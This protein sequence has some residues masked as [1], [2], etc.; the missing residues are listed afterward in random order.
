MSRPRA[1]RSNR[2]PRR[3]QGRLGQARHAARGT[4]PGARFPRHPARDALAT[5]FP[6]AY[7]QRTASPVTQ[8]ALSFDAG[9]AADPLDRRGIQNMTLRAA[10]RRRRRANRPADRGGE[11]AARRRRSTPPAAADRS[12]VTLSALSANLAPSLALMRDIVLTPD[13]NPAEVDRVRGQLLTA[14]AQAKKNPGRDRP[15]RASAFAVRRRAI[16]MRRPRLATKR[17]SRRS[18]ATIC[19]RSRTAGCGPTRPSCSSFP[20]GRWPRSCRCSRRRSA[21]GTAPSAPA[22]T[23]NFSVAPPAATG[24]A[25]R[26]RRPARIRRSRSSMRARSRRSSP[27]ADIVPIN[28]ATDVFGGATASRTDLDLREAKGWSYGA[29]GGLQIARPGRALSDPG[30]GPGGPHRRFDRRDPRIC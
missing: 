21:V 3:P 23:K 8:L 29:Y 15:A 27:T 7:A 11:G 4:G 20:T 13:F 30:A 19:S 26:P 24:L 25:D 1:P 2:R 16:P 17:R 12:I 6:I 9:F 10:R 28:A 18:P 22:G 14:V 5:A